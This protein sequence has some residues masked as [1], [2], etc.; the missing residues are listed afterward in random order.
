MAPQSPVKA[1]SLIELLVALGILAIAAAIIVPAYLNVQSQAKATVIQQMADQLNKTYAD[2]RAA[3]GIVSGV[4][5]GS[6]I[7]DV[8]GTPSSNGVLRSITSPSNDATVSDNNLSSTISIQLPAGTPN[9]DPSVTAPTD[10]VVST[11]Y[12]IN[13]SSGTDSFTVMPAI[14]WGGE[15]IAGEMN[16]SWVISIGANNI[17]SVLYKGVLIGI[18]TPPQ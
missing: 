5:H 4:P 6:M 18:A 15:D 13:Y 10:T 16:G 17:R 2:W 14:N 7:L 12:Q 3:G 11:S 8:L 9:L 1:F